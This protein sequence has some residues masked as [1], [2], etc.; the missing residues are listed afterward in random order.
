[1]VGLSIVVSLK[2]K[3]TEENRGYKEDKTEKKRKEKEEGRGGEGCTE[4]KVHSR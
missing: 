4:G 1:M 3:K 2:Q